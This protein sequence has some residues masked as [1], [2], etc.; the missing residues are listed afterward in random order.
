MRFAA[1]ADVHGNCVALEAVL[2]DIHALGIRNVVN[3][4]DHLSGPLE[5]RRTVDLLMGQEITSIRGNHDRQLVELS[6]DAMGLSDR[7]AH[8][9]LEGRHLDWLAG[10]PASLTFCDEVFLCHATPQ[11]DTTYWLE[12]VTD[13]GR[14]CATPIEEVEQRASGI[15]ASLILC[16]HTHIPRVVR[17]RDGRLIV[18]PGS[19]GCPAYDAGLPVPH[20]METGTPNACYAVLE[21]SRSGWS[22]TF[23]FVPYDHLSMAEMAR[24][25]GRAEWASAL[26]SGWIR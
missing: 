11:S 2:R 15:D 8:Q 9:Q 1:I 25:N 16:G 19:V 13:E 7:A 17:L 23:R 10:L 4:G 20:K 3:L 26:T 12:T 24:R 18:N 5:A 6:L 21:R 22:T 14:V